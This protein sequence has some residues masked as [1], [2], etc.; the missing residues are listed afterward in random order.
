MSNGCNKRTALFPSIMKLLWFL[1]IRDPGRGVGRACQGSC[2]CGRCRPYRAAGLSPG[3][4]PVD[5]GAGSCCHLVAACDRRRPALSIS[6]VWIIVQPG[7][8]KKIDEYQR[9]LT[10]VKTSPDQQASGVVFKFNLL[11]GVCFFSPFC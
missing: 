1:I 9:S 3:C 5:S 2:N 4:A 6:W 8:G 7:K 11:C 10:N